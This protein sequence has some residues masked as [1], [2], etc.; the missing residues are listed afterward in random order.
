MSQEIERKRDRE[1]ETERQTDREGERER[2]VQV[3]IPF[4]SL[5]KMWK[6]MHLP[7]FGTYESFQVSASL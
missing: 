4:A 1:K 3:R 6:K 5:Q 2:E 7:S